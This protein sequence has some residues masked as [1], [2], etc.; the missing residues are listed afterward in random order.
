VDFTDL[1]NLIK[2]DHPEKK[3]PSFDTKNGN[4]SAKFLFLLEAPGPQAVDNSGIVSFGNSD[5]T[6]RN[7]LK[8]LEE[9]QIPRSEIA[10]WN[11][12]PWYIGNPEG[13][14]IRA[15][16]SADIQSGMLYLPKLIEPMLN[17][18]FI[19]LVGSSARK[20]HLLLSRTT[21]ARI[22]SCHHTSGR[23]MR[24]SQDQKWRENVEILKFIK[25]SKG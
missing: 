10:I 9:A 3:V 21:E 6:A 23:V 2:A 20:A 17:L 15:A 1:V 5:P 16:T 13:T 25:V 22:V 7:F 24:S 19:I 4:E 11:I 18:K 14:A 8:Q 12:V